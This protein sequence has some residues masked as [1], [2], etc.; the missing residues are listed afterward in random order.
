MHKRGQ[1]RLRK[2][3]DPAGL[4][5]PPAHAGGTDFMTAPPFQPF[6]TQRL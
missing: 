5:D 6:P 2:R 1:Y 3:A 4:L